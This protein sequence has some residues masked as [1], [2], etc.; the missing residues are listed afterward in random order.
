MSSPGCIALSVHFHLPDQVH[1]GNQID[2]SSFIFEQFQS[3][4]DILALYLAE[5]LPLVQPL[6]RLESLLVVE[7]LCL[8]L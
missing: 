4:I 2:N 1:Q 6:D 3:F 5:F 8:L 7:H